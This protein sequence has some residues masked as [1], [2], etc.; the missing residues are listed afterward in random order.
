MY[1]V[2]LTCIQTDC[3]FP[4]PFRPWE[5]VKCWILI[6]YSYNDIYIVN[7][8]AGNKSCP[9]PHHNAGV[10]NADG[11]KMETASESVT[12]G[13]PK[14][15]ATDNGKRAYKWMGSMVA[16][17]E[18]SSNLIKCFL[19]LLSTHYLRFHSRNCHWWR[20]IYSPL[21]FT[22][23]IH[24]FDCDYDFLAFD[25]V[26]LPTRYSAILAVHVHWDCI[27]DGQDIWPGNI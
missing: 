5:I 6:I 8:F 3:H 26:M 7:Y 25:F 12:E 15:V 19:G 22:T 11:I 16:A 4:L 24:E 27:Q 14:T 18:W 13:K 9:F 20:V 1:N 21:D 2:D 10:V 17:L 23:R